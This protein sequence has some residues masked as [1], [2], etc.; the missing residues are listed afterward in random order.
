MFV[1]R[2]SRLQGHAQPFAL[3]TERTTTGL[4]I[5]GAAIAGSSVLL[6][7]VAATLW[8]A[9]ANMSAPS[10]LARFAQTLIPVSYF[11]VYLVPGGFAF[12]VS[13]VLLHKSFRA[14]LD[15]PFMAAFACAVVAASVS[16]I[17]WRSLTGPF[18]ASSPGP[19][20]SFETIFIIVVGSLIV[21]AFAGM[22]SSLTNRHTRAP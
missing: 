21:A 7:L 20:T 22:C 2:G 16:F 17:V 13:F 18:F 19:T 9:Y 14:S 10:V 15:R 12:V 8:L 4:V 3:K 6:C 11:I 1:R 5:K